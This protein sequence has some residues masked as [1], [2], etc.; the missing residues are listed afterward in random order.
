MNNRF[1]AVQ[2]WTYWSTFAAKTPFSTI[3]CPGVS[4]SGKRKPVFK[5]GNYALRTFQPINQFP[6]FRR[7]SLN[8]YV[9][10][11]SDKIMWFHK[12]RLSMHTNNSS[13]KLCYS[14][15][16]RFSSDR[17]FISSR[18]KCP[19]FCKFAHWL[20]AE[21]GTCKVKDE[22]KVHIAFFFPAVFLSLRKS[23]SWSDCISECRGDPWYFLF[24][25]PQ[26]RVYSKLNRERPLVVWNSLHSALL[27]TALMLQTR[28][29]KN[30]FSH[31]LI[32]PA[33]FS[34]NDEIALRIEIQC[35]ER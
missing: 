3:V 20:K 13:F 1:Q 7:F 34:I 8:L 9:C 26:W 5:T 4:F 15:T 28:R 30:W 22:P 6:S 33:Y 25:S 12:Q 23:L 10:F 29:P 16:D 17:H 2:I 21:F 11:F 32:V 19:I 18:S 27:S 35:A 31:L 14:A 24:L